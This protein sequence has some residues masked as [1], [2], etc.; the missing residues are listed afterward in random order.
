MPSSALFAPDT[1]LA[2]TQLLVVD[3]EEDVLELLREL[4]TMFGATVVV[5]ASAE[6]AFARLEQHV[7]DAL[8]SDI[9]MPGGTGLDLMRRVRALPAESGGG[10]PAIALSGAS[11]ADQALAA[12]FHVLVTKPVR[13]QKLVDTIR[14]ILH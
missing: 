12:G 6:E 10:V 1:K 2:G 8:I 3:D 7:P 11:S 4:L 5:A 14:A 13:A 9:Q